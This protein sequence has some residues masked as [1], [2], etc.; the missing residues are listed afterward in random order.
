MENIESKVANGD[1]PKDRTRSSRR[2]QR[3]RSPL[4]FLFW[5]R[6]PNERAEAPAKAAVVREEPKQ[7]AVD[8]QA[9]IEK[10]MEELRAKN[11]ELQIANEQMADYH[12]NLLATVASMRDEQDKDKELHEETVKSLKDCQA[13]LAVRQAEANDRQAE[14]HIAQAELAQLKEQVETVTQ[15]R[16]TAEENIKSLQEVQK[17]SLAVISEIEGKVQSQH[18]EASKLLSERTSEIMSHRNDISRLQRDNSLLDGQLKE[19]LKE[20]ELLAKKMSRRCF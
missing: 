12:E 16:N 7:E 10:E 18:E 15:Q 3:A 17:R 20:K 19:A 6:K 1:E 4:P 13:E 5:K 11:R 2:S 9:D 8:K 14:I